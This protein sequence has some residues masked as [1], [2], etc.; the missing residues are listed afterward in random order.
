MGGKNH[1]I[2][3]SFLS[4]STDAFS[5]LDMDVTATPEA[6]VIYDEGTG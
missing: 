3:L 1:L 6:Y 4:P 2:V 5:G